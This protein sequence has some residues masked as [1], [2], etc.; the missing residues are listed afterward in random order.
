MRGIDS[1]GSETHRVLARDPDQHRCAAR[2]RREEGG[3]HRLGSSRRL[4]RVVDAA[5]GRLAHRRSRLLGAPL[6]GDGVR[7]AERAR[8]LQLLR[9]R[10]RPR[11]RARRRRRPPP[12]S[13]D[14]PTPPQPITATRSPGRT[15]AVRQTAPTPVDTAQPTSAGDLERHVVG[16][17]H[18]RP[19]GDD[20]RLGERREERVVVDG[21]AV[22]REPGRP[23]HQAAGAHRRPRGRAELRQ[24]AQAL[25]AA[26]RTTAPRRARRGR[27]RRRASRPARP[28]RRRR[29]PR[30]R[31]PRGS[32]SRPCRRSRCSPSGRPRSRASRTS[33]S[34][35]PGG[36]RSSSA[37]SS[38]PPVCSSTAARILT[39][40]LDGALARPGSAARELLDRDVAAHLVARLDLGQRRLC[41]SQIAPSLRGQR[42][43]KTQPDGGS[44]ALGMSPS[45]RIRSRCR[46]RSSAPPRA[47][48]RCTGGAARRRRRSAGPS[49]ISRP[50]Y[51]TAMRS[52]R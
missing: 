18:A 28:P 8:D 11:R 5:T 1:A 34:P 52:E 32:A 29:R 42:V 48:P 20:A 16:D 22:A 2:A 15:P 24:V 19:L 45:R 23:V 51:S 49:S 3:Q 14:S 37:T 27:R 17:R 30:D 35:G 6:P 25:L 39:H 38:G 10:R 43:W 9:R 21:L 46:R 12:S 13:A 33:T 50:R 7:R 40:A 31:A 44:A 26:P 4:D 41:S 47:A 36:A